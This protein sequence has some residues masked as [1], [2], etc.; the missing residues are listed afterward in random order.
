MHM[1][2][3]LLFSC[4]IVWIASKKHHPSS[5]TAER[6]INVLNCRKEYSAM[7]YTG[8]FLL[9]VFDY[10]ADAIGIIG[11]RGN[12]R[13]KK[14]NKVVALSSIPVFSFTLSMIHRCASNVRSLVTDEFCHVQSRELS[15]WQ[16]NMAP[17]ICSINLWLP[18]SLNHGDCHQEFPLDSLSVFRWYILPEYTHLWRRPR[19]GV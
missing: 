15:K 5:S 16:E 9:R 14:W 17:K 3:H 19:L 4:L 2:V 8:A 18:L 10:R 1:H 11:K 6:S 7:H 13:G 12:P